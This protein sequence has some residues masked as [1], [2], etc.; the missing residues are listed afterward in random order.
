MVRKRILAARSNTYKIGITGN[1]C[2]GKTLVRNILERYG[3][4]TLDPE[5]T[6]MNLL[7]DNPARLGIK[8]TE[9]YGSQV[10]DSRGRLSRKKLSS[11]LYRDTDKKAFFD[12]HLESFIRAE[13]KKFLFRPM[14]S[15]LR[16]VE[17]ANLLE[18][19]TKHLY[20]E[21]WVV[22]TNP[23]IQI[24]RLMQREHLTQAEARHL[25]DTQWPQNLKAGMGNRVIDNSQDIQ[26]T[27]SQVRK[28]LDELNLRTLKVSF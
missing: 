19:D 3:L 17:S 13:I 23:E 12:S 20:D 6:V 21:V 9:D 27:E 7:I 14:G 22:T 28:A 24:Q 4:D 16:A 26:E 8:L 2:T 18:E 1:V 25:I 11:L 15:P 5:N 10:L